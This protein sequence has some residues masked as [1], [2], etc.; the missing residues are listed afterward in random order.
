MKVI[1]DTNVIVS[2]LLTPA[3]L[4]AVI[5]NL[6]LRGTVTVVYDNAIMAEYIDVLGREKL[7]I[8]RELADLV[9]DFISKEGEYTIANSHKIH[10]HFIDEDDRK[11][12]EL[13]KTGGINYLITGNTRHFPNERGIVTPR[14][15]MEKEYALT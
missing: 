8:N 7:K 4:P 5:L 11:F 3:G 10:F 2:A 6:V 13:F 1:L 9:I 12:Y 14:K 15:F